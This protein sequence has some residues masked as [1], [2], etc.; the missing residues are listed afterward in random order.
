MENPHQTTSVGNS[1]LN[2]CDDI[3]SMW[4]SH[5][6]SFIECGK[7]TLNGCD[8]IHSIRNFQ[9]MSFDVDFPYSLNDFFGRVHMRL[10]TCCSVIDN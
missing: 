2:E 6:H 9:R 8:H 5:I 7:S 4:I 1:I 10:G 3:K